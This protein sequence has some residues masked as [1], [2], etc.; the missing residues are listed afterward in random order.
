MSLSFK[1]QDFNIRLHWG[2]Q[3][4]LWPEKK[5]ITSSL[6][7]N[8][9][10]IIVQWSDHSEEWAICSMF[11]SCINTKYLFHKILSL[12]LCLWVCFFIIIL[13]QSCLQL[14][15]YFSYMWCPM[16]CAKHRW[17]QPLSTFIHICLVLFF[18]SADYNS[19]FNPT[20]TFRSQRRLFK[21]MCID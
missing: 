5:L 4:S 17:Y 18:S 13:C 16:Y 2:Y 12:L 11:L 14:L 21:Q 3:F 20:N 9:E 6:K 1:V 10:C 8:S 7:V 15:L 19:Y